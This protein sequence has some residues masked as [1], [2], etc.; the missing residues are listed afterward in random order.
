MEGEEEEYANLP[1]NIKKMFL[2]RKGAGV[3]LLSLRIDVP[4]IG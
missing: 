4:K 2:L 3:N 1:E